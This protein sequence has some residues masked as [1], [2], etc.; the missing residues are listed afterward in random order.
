MTH[1]LCLSG[2]AVVAG[3]AERE[4]GE[5]LRL[6]GSERDG[7]RLL[8]APLLYPELRPPPRRPRSP[9]RE[10]ERERD[11][12]LQRKSDRAVRNNFG[13]WFADKLK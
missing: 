13:Q 8:L 9:E 3:W 11:R 12:D 7:L 4:E 10:R 6:T 5:G 1:F 2:T